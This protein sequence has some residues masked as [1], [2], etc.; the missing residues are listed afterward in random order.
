MQVAGGV[1]KVG[2]LGVTLVEV[3]MVL[4]VVL[5]VETFMLIG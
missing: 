3:V 5:I 2:C 1:T 4:A